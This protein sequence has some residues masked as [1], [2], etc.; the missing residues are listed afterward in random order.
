MEN[1]KRPSAMANSC[2]KHSK[3]KQSPGVCSLCLRERLSKISSSSLQAV[4]NVSSSSSSSSSSYVS[5]SHCSSNAE[6]HMASPMHN[7]RKTN[8]EFDGNSKGYLSSLKKSRSVAFFVG[9]KMVESDGKKKKRDGFWSRLMMG[10][11]RRNTHKRSKE[12]EGSSRLMHSR[13]MREMLNK[14]L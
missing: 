1:R 2:T 9:E 6:S 3:H 8:Y 5:S 14:W 13:T 12:S 10:S 7:Y 11:K 4:T